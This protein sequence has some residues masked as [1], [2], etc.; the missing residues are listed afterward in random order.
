MS[1]SEYLIQFGDARRG[2][3]RDEWGKRLKDVNWFFPEKWIF[4]FRK[5]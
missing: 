3:A 2:L 4:T 1:F 5:P